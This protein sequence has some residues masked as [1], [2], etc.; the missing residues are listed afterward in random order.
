MLK[1]RQYIYIYI[2]WRA[3]LNETFMAKYDG[4]RPKS[5]IYS[6][7]RDEEHP[8]HFHMR[9]PLPLPPPGL[10]SNDPGKTGNNFF[11]YGAMRFPQY[12]KMFSF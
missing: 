6:P 7:K 4:V 8:H 11:C 5:E 3:T 2:F 1:H 9:S 12:I 10:L